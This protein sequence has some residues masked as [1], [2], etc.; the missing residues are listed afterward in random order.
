[1][2]IKLFCLENGKTP[3]VQHTFPVNISREETVGDLK[4]AIKAKKA[5]Y[6]NDF[7]ADHLKLWLANIPVDRDDLIQNQTLQDNNQLPATNDIEDHWTDTPLK[8]H[9][10]IIVEVPI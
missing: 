3:A 8:K 9:I 2:S 10:H 4:D 7:P 6:F 5:P 1:M